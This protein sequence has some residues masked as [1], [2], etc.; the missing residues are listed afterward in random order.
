[1]KLHGDVKSL[2]GGTG[3]KSSMVEVKSS[4]ADYRCD[5]GAGRVRVMMTMVVQSRGC[6]ESV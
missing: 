5:A 3:V 6:E 2:L 1:V 4:M